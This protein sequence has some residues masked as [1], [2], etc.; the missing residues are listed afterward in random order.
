MQS[1]SRKKVNIKNYG[2]LIIKNS[3]EKHANSYHMN[4]LRLFEPL[5]YEM[6]SLELLLR[7]D[8]GELYKN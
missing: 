7:I 6:K 1:Y 5:N 3:D 4:Y 8:L 2:S